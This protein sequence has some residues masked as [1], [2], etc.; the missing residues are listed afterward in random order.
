VG[1]TTLLN[2]LAARDI[3]GFPE[4]L[5]V[6][7]VQH[8][9]LANDEQ[10]VIN[11]MLSAQARLGLTQQ[12]DGDVSQVRDSQSRHPPVSRVSLLYYSQPRDQ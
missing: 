6:V 2:R 11:Y 10:S 7:Y 8:E 3:S 12:N 9:I 1:K 4:H 5:N